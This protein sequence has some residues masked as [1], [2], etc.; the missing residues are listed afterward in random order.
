MRFVLESNHDIH[1]LEVG[2]LSV[3]PEAESSWGQRTFIK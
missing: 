1:M 3:L 2:Q